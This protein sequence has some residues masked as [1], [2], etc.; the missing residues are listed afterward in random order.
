[1]QLFS[2]IVL[3]KL[4]KIRAISLF[5]VVDKAVFESQGS[6]SDIFRHCL[7]IEKTSKLTNDPLG[8]VVFV[9]NI[10]CSYTKLD[11]ID[12]ICLANV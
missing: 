1:M 2:K 11:T 7:I 8:F 6:P 3:K 9:N 5:Q 4:S 10:L 12:N